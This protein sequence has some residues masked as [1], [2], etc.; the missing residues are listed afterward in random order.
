M[1]TYPAADLQQTSPRMNGDDARRAGI[2]AHHRG[3]DDD[4]NVLLSEIAAPDS[5]GGLQA[6]G[7][8]DAF[9]G[10]PRSVY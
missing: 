9:T 5:L 7:V 4:L 10:G 8:D 2:F 1:F 6:R 3:V